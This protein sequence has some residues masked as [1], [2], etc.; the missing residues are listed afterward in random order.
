MSRRGARTYRTVQTDWPQGPERSFLA[1]RLHSTI[2]YL[3]TAT[4]TGPHVGFSSCSLS[5]KQRLPVSLPVMAAGGD[6]HMEPIRRGS[7]SSWCWQVRTYYLPRWPCQ[8]NHLTSPHL[9]APRP[10]SPPLGH[11]R[12]HLVLHR[13]TPCRSAESGATCILQIAL[14][15]P[16]DQTPLP[17]CQIPAPHHC[18]L[19][20]APPRVRPYP[21]WQTVGPEGRRC[22][23]ALGS[24]AHP[25][26]VVPSYF[27]SILPRSC[28]PACGLA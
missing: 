4:A 25:T 22:I 8:I 28:L 10:N 17:T 19:C 14:P 7:R 26:P 21:D 16:I 3:G 1:R 23:L 15:Q 24:Q 5:L 12:L 9:T 2:M 6:R 18:T 13:E 20:A 27:S 11:I